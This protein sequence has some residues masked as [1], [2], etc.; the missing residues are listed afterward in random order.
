MNLMFLII[1]EWLLLE[2]GE[3]YFKIDNC[4]LFEYLLVVFL[5]YNMLL[6]FVF[7]DLYNSDYEGNIKIEYEEKFLV[8]GFFIYCFEVKFDRN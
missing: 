6:I 1:Y 7:F 4:S 8:K 3:I 2:V 5:E